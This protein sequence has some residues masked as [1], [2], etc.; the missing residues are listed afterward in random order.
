MAQRCEGLELLAFDGF[1]WL[2]PAYKYNW[3]DKLAKMKGQP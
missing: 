2:S 1:Q 3:L